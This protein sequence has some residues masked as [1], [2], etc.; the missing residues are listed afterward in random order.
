MLRR[1]KLLRPQIEF[2]VIYLNSKLRSRRTLRPPPFCQK[3]CEK[4]ERREEFS[5]QTLNAGDEKV[6]IA[7]NFDF[8]AKFVFSSSSL[9]VEYLLCERY[10][11]FHAEPFPS[12]F[13]EI[14][15]LSLDSV[16][17]SVEFEFIIISHP[18]IVRANE[19][20]SIDFHSWL[21]LHPSWWAC[22]LFADAIQ[23]QARSMWNQ[24][25]W[26]EFQHSERA[27][28]ITLINHINSFT[29]SVLAQAAAT[30]VWSKLDST[31][32]P[33]S[34]LHTSIDCVWSEQQQHKTELIS[35]NEIF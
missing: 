14:I 7:E 27:R 15:F 19:R 23:D 35:F 11:F 9:L 30:A 6:F 5:S 32:T 2:D 8:I 10:I 13:L 33:L 24:F 31:L 17:S 20:G 22:I 34:E 12:N 1:E 16:K 21:V 25:E 3:K 28:I 4:S 29:W 18:L 26:N